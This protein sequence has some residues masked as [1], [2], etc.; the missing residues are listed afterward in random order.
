MKKRRIS[1]EVAMQIIFQLEAQGIIP[2]KQVD[3]IAF[4]KDVKLE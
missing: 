2:R 1:R 3:D 4:K